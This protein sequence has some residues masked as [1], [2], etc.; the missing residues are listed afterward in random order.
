MNYG[1]AIFPTKQLQDLANSYRKRYD[2][3]YALLPPHITLKSCF[4][5]SEAEITTIVNQVQQIVHEVEPFTIEITKAKSFHPSNNTI[6]L[7]VE[8]SPEL[9]KLHNSLHSEE[10][11]KT[12]NSDYTFIPHLTIAQELSNDEHMDLLGQLTNL[13]VSHQETVDRIHL[14][15]Q[16]EDGTWTIYETFRLGAE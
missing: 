9:E 6:Y 5:A 8:L 15:Y 13:N 10:F 4:E 16:L 12:E 14:L 7:K 3:K 1:I 11:F 2:K